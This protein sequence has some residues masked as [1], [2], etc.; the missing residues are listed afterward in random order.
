MYSFELE[1]LVN[2]IL[3]AEIEV[4]PVASNNAR[5]LVVNK[6]IPKMAQQRKGWHMT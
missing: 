5:I 1:Y 2:T 6:L 4:V 3:K